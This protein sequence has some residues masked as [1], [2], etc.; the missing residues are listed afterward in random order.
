VTPAGWVAGLLGWLACASSPPPVA[1]PA[2][3]KPTEAPPPPAPP[4]ATSV[5]PGPTLMGT[6]DASAGRWHEGLL[7]VADDERNDLLLFDAD[8]L[9]ARAVPLAGAFPALVGKEADLEAVARHSDHTWWIGSHDRGKGTSPREARQRLFQ[10]DGTTAGVLRTDLLERLAQHEEVARVLAATEGITSKHRS[11]LSIEGLAADDDGLWV[12]FRAPVVD[13]R[14]LVVH[15]ADPAGGAIPSAPVWLDLGG[16]GVRALERVGSRIYVVAGPAEADGAFAVYRWAPGTPDT[17]Q[18]LSSQQL[19]SL[20]PEG[21]ALEPSTGTLW[22][23]SDD[24][25]LEIE[26]RTCKKLPPAARRARTAIF[27]PPP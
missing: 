14:A 26:G 11:G 7:Q 20:R 10:H 22:L 25:G 21:L 6:C 17:E 2:P 8:G 27:T 19:G 4:A 18:V 23:L 1:I 15:V 5:T 24:G 3:P 12:G 13:G 16:R 9:L